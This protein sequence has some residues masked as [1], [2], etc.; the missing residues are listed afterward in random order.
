MREAER[1]DD[2]PI[3]ETRALTND[4]LR[5]ELDK[6]L[7]ELMNLRFR[8]ATRQLTNVSQIKKVRRDI[9]RLKTILRER[10]LE[11]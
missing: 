4:G 1:S 2:M 7:K 6:A 5:E 10:G 3:S 8:V 9:A 11:A